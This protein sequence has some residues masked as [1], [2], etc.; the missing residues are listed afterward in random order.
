MLDRRRRT[1]AIR[2]NVRASVE[3]AV[4]FGLHVDDGEALLVDA[5]LG[6][7]LSPIGRLADD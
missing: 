6:F 2:F 5:A 3:T 1:T 7:S 4:V